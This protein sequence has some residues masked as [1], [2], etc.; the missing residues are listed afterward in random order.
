MNVTTRSLAWWHALLEQPRWFCWRQ[1]VNSP[2]MTDLK[3]TQNVDYTPT[4][5]PKSHPTL[6][7]RASA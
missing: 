6:D 2:K 1:N 7:L 5:S 3:E 4:Q